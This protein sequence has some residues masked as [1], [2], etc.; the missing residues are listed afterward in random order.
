MQTEVD[1]EKGSINDRR[2][3]NRETKNR[4]NKNKHKNK[5]EKINETKIEKELEEDLKKLQKIDS[6]HPK[7]FENRHNNYKG[8][9]KE[10]FKH[11]DHNGETEYDT[12]NRVVDS[13]HNNDNYNNKNDKTR[14]K[15]K[16]RFED[17]KKQDIKNSHYKLNDHYDLYGG[18]NSKDNYIM[19]DYNGKHIDINSA[20]HNEKQTNKNF[21]PKNNFQGFHNN[22]NYNSY[23]Y[24][25]NK[26]DSYD[27]NRYPT[28]RGNLAGNHAL[29]YHRWNNDG[30]KKQWREDDKFNVVGNNMIGTHG[31]DASYKN[32]N[33]FY[34]DYYTNNGKNVNSNRNNYFHNTNTYRQNYQHQNGHLNDKNTGTNGKMY[35]KDPH[36]NTMYFQPHKNLNQFNS[37]EN[38]VS[39]YFKSNKDYQDDGIYKQ[40]YNEHRYAITNRPT[41]MNYDPK[42]LTNHHHLGNAYR[43]PHQFYNYPF[44]A[45]NG[46]NNANRQMKNER[47]HEKSEIEAKKEKL[48][49]IIT[50]YLN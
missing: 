36:K 48:D 47:T 49:K 26:Y 39:N 1:V 3:T 20:N 2:R 45:N 37:H 17:N 40:S 6:N 12:F 41:Y 8:Q 43:N 46:H 32:N 44:Q 28:P 24:N 18:K 5:N 27:R 21:N 11:D 13:I 42:P 4:K 29:N 14:N 9:L 7:S 34:H 30:K 31:N 23:M 22:G 38:T 19:G 16:G 50:D 25:N 15:N 35:Q 33:I 10:N